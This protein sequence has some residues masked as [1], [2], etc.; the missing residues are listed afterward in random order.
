MNQKSKQKNNKQCKNG[1]FQASKQIKLR[2]RLWKQSEYMR[3]LSLFALRKNEISCLKNYSD[4][5][6]TEMSYLVNSKLLEQ[7]IESKFS[8]KMN[9][10]KFYNFR[11]A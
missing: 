6:N 10:I 7:E 1:F 8:E 4:V 2:Q 5:F 11:E 9:K 3:F